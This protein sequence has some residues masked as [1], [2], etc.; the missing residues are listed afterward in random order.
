MKSAQG[1]RTAGILA[2]AAAVSAQLAASQAMAQGAEEPDAL[3]EITVTG[4]RIS[5]EGGFTAPTPVTTLSSDE[6]SRTAAPTVAAALN[7]LPSFTA[8]TS[9]GTNTFGVGN[10]GATILDL[11]NLGAQRTLVLV[12]GRRFVPGTRQGTFDASLVPNALIERAE[13]VTGGASAA[14]G[15]DAVAGVV[16][17]FLNRN[18]EGLRG[19]LQY[20]E[21]TYGDSPEMLASLAGGSSFAD[22]RGH[23]IFGV[24]F[25]KVGAAGD[26]FSRRWCSPNGGADGYIIGNPLG[27]G[28]GGYPANIIGQ[29]I[30]STMTRS[31]LIT[32]G[33]LRGTQF[34]P[35]G[36]VSNTPFTYGPVANVFY[37]LA[38]PDPANPLSRENLI[39]GEQLFH[40]EIPLRQKYERY[41]AFGHA[42]FEF[43]ESLS[44]FAE[45]S[46]GR[47]RSHGPVQ[48]HRATGNMTIRRDNAFLPASL[49]QRMDDLGVTNFGFGRITLQPTEGEEG[50][51]Q[52]ETTRAALGLNGRLAGTWTWD[53]YY[54]YGLTR[55][56]TLLPHAPIPG[57]ITL[58][59]DAVV[60]P[61]NGQIVCRS[62]LTAP[63][64][65]CAPINPF[66]DGTISAAGLAWGWATG[67]FRDE[68]EEHVVAANIQGDP[69]R[70]WAGAVSVAAG[71][72]YRRDT[73]DGVSDPISSALRFYTGNTTPIDGKISV[74]EAYLETVVPLASDLAFARSL[75]LN[76]AYRTTDYS[77]SGS[78]N[79]WKVGLTW[80]PV[81]WLRLRG[82]RSRDIRSPNMV[83]LFGATSA[84]IQFVRDPVTNTDINSRTLTGG[85]PGLKPE[86]ADTWTAGLVLQPQ[87][88][89]M[90]GT[91]RFSLDRFDITLDG[92]IAQFGAQNI[93]NR[94]FSG[95]S[96][97]CPLIERDAGNNIVSIFNGSLNLNQVQTRGWD[98][99]ALY[100]LPLAN[101]RDSWAGTLNWRAVATKTDDLITVF[102]SGAR[103]DRAGQNGSPVSLP[104]G[105]PDWK[106]YSSLD[107]SRGPVR[108]GL[109]VRWWPAGKYDANL[110]GP[111]DPGYSITLR[112]SV[113]TN[114]VAGITY[115]DLNGSYDFTVGD[116]GIQLYGAV[117]NV[118]DADPPLSPGSQG[119]YNGYLYDA[120]G[121]TYRV[122]VR[123]QF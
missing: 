89:L 106:L 22:G 42:D 19:Q 98:V 23:A 12:D 56:S 71:V 33:P 103:E 48:D 94:C 5:R 115:L 59:I 6:M 118:T 60:N 86:V 27:P 13:V 65:G 57:N 68:L 69:F 61:A 119:P 75:E 45:A 95:E 49:G 121:R 32:S 104:S 105:V 11:R 81:D 111:E 82:T 62:T 58:G 40:Q 80:E 7:N 18:L 70:T 91:F 50:R 97:Y 46:F 64:N 96:E 92:A 88:P 38:Q 66:G 39:P 117:V 76:G 99:E 14:Y 85:N 123:V 41:T 47:A 34:N 116:H 31:G 36:S 29:M 16:N 25:N 87:Q 51:A 78:A 35:D 4:S 15:S 67:W 113:N 112:N 21:T 54:Q 2:V 109:G 90:G 120:L 100:N 114:R 72:E 52:R 84:G 55:S 63:N 9:S 102:A 79:T 24:E 1:I 77:T 73:V 110:V 30:T 3:A 26:C 43:T 37:T 28:G 93:V 122:G 44:A 17:L 10:A 74:K 101:V 20:G 53:A 83:E 108:M 8:S 107:Y